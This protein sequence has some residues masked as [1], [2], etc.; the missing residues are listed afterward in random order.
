MDAIILPTLPMEIVNRI[1]N[2]RETNEVAKC[3]R[4]LNDTLFRLADDHKNLYVLK[5]DAHDLFANKKQPSVMLGYKFTFMYL[6]T[7]KYFLRQII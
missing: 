2:M 1:L 6:S 4:A 3:I 7:H 5:S